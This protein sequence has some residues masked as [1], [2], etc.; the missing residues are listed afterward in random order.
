MLIT[1]ITPVYNTAEYLPECIESVMNQTCDDWELILVNDGSTDNSGAI[2]DEYARK[3]ERISVIHKENSGQFP[4]RMAGIERAKGRYCT[5]LDSDDYLEPNCVEVLKQTVQEHPADIICWNIRN[6]NADG[7]FTTD[8]KDHYGYYTSE[9]FLEYVAR[10][11]D[12][13]F[14]DKMIDT[15]MMKRSYYGNVPDSKRS[16]DYIQIA[17]SLCMANTVYAIDAALYN[18]RQVGSSVSHVINGKYVIDNLESEKCVLDIISYYGK[19]T[20][21]FEKAEYKC[22]LG[23]IGIGIK[24]SFKRSSITKDEIRTI[25]NHPVFRSLKKYERCKYGTSDIVFVMKM[26]RYGLSAVLATMYGAGKCAE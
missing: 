6:V 21:Q 26:F 18:Y 7:S 23:V 4:S 2:C 9:N 10:S 17:P 1:F 11:S 22:L 25:R 5:D 8:S 14:S 12:H 3:D 15:S 20:P 24:Q 13:S 19:I 16:V